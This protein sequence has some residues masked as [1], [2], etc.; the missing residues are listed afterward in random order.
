MKRKGAEGSAGLYRLSPPANEEFTAMV[1]ALDRLS[2]PHSGWDPY[3]VWRTRVKG[4]ASVLWERDR[5]P[6]RWLLRARAAGRRLRTALQ[7]VTNFATF[8]ADLGRNVREQCILA[9]ENLR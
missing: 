7:S 1:N 5:A 8:A 3:E 2:R 6:S 4:S 9:L